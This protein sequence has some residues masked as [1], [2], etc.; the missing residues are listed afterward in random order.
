ML[1]HALHRFDRAVAL[2]AGDVAR[3][4]RTVVER[5]EVRHLVDA[6]PLDRL[7]LD[8]GVALALVV[9][10]ERAVQLAKLRRKMTGRGLRPSALAASAFGQDVGARSALT[11]LWQFMQMPAGGMAAWRDCVAA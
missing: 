4:V 8:R 10:T 5:D 7:R 11:A 6:H 9:E 1:A 2:L 3:D